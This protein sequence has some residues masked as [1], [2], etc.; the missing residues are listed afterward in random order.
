VGGVTEFLKQNSTVPSSKLH[1]GCKHGNSEFL[2]RG[3]IVT[4]HFSD[5][6]ITGIVYRIQ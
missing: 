3:P 4:V 5:V 1:D 6:L 2:E